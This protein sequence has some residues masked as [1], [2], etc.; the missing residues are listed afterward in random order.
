MELITGFPRTWKKHDSIMVVV[1]RLG[2]VS[3]FIV[4][5]STNTASEVA[6]IFI[7]EIVSLYG[8]PN[9][10]ISTKVP[11]SLLRLGRRCMQAWGQSYLSL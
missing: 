3:H 1:D 9:D 7:R 2:K 6:Q 4:V 5:K 8:I 10:I 11:S